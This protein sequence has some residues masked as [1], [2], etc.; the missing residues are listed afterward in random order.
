MTERLPQRFFSSF[1]TPF[2]GPEGSL[3]LAVYWRFSSPGD[4][5]A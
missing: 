2:S 4:F 5:S 3:F 1:N